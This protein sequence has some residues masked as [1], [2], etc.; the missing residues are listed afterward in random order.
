MKKAKLTRRSFVGK[1]T[2]ASAGIALLTPA[3]PGFPAILKN[4][5]K[6]N[7]KINGVQLGCITYSFRSMNTDAESVLKYCV[8]A[9]IS[10]IELMGTTAEAFAGAPH[11]STEPMAPFRPGQQRPQLTPE[12]QAE[13]DQRAKDIQAWRATVG[14]EKFEQLRKMYKEAGVSIYAYKPNAFGVN[15]SDAEVNY[16]MRAARALGAWHVTLEMPTQAGQTKRLAEL[17]AANSVFVAYHGHEQQTPKLWDAAIKE[18][19]F[20]LMNC[21]LGHYTAAGFDAV[22]LVDD[23]QDKIAS[24]HIKDRQNLKNGRANLPWG[25]GDTPIVQ[26]LQL[27]RK[28]KMKFPATIELEY[29]IPEGSDAVKEVAKC[30]EYSRKALEQN[31]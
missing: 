25:T 30:L 18:S 20:N 27:M 7:S 21:D 4:L 31:S 3:F 29:E 15:N 26:I 17:G 9:G 23:K 22:A 10:A 12:Q 19:K 14:M 28:K 16:G 11:T 2:A 24:A 8:D 1:L 13:R 6:P 5:G